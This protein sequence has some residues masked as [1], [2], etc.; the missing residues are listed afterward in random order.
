MY[1][2]EIDGIQINNLNIIMKMKLYY[3]I[4]TFST[5]IK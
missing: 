4:I 1:G 5:N 3:F 2:L